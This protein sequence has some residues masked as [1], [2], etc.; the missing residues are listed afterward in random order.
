MAGINGGVGIYMIKILCGDM[1]ISKFNKILRKTAK[2][3]YKDCW[4]V[5]LEIITA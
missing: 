3:K 4:K 1:N 5:I 2:K